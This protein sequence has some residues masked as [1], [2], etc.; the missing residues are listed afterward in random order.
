MEKRRQSTSHFASS[1]RGLL[2]PDEEIIS[3]VALK[4]ERR[5]TWR[6]QFASSS[7]SPELKPKMKPIAWM[8]FVCPGIITS[9]KCPKVAMC[10]DYPS[11]I[12]VFKE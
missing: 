3:G 2:S 12:R 5:C 8:A 11:Q 10:L 6:P 7:S 1:K 9:W 4:E